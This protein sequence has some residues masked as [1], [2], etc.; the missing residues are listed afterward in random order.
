MDM[1][2]AQDGQ[3]E[4]HEHTDMKILIQ[5]METGIVLAV[6]DGSFSQDMKAVAWTIEA[7]MEAG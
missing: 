7:T 6:S 5:A 4:I 2:Y 3:L 1:P